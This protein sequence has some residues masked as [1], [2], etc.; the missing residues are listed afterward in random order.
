VLVATGRQV[1]NKQLVHRNLAAMWQQF[2]DARARRLVLCQ[3]LEDRGMLRHVCAAVPSAEITVVHL[4]VPYRPCTPGCA[5]ARPDDTR[6]G[7]ST[8]RP[9]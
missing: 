3:V 6:P 4:H 9:T 1:W 7:T 5:G 2:R 8:P